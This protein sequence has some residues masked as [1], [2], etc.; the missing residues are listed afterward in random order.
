MPDMVG[1]VTFGSFDITVYAVWSTDY[2]N[3]GIPDVFQ[4]GFTLTYDANGGTGAPVDTHI[5]QY[6]ESIAVDDAAG[7]MMVAPSSNYVFMYWTDD[8]GV[9]PVYVLGDDRNSLPAEVHNITFSTSNVILYAVWGEDANGNGT[10]DILEDKYELEYNG[11]GGANVPPKS[12]G[13]LLNDTIVLDD[14][15]SMTN[16]SYVFVGWTLAEP[17]TYSSVYTVGEEG[18]LPAIVTDVT[19]TS[20]DIIVYA[21]W[22][23]DSNGNGIPDVYEDAYTVT[24]DTNGGTGSQTDANSYLMGSTATVLDQNDMANGTYA[25]IG[26]NTEA[27]GS[28]TS[29]AAGD[30]FTI[31]ADTVLFAQWEITQEILYTVTYDANGGTGGQTDANSPY[32][33]GSTVTVLDKND[34]ANGA[35]I[36]IGW[37]T[38]ADGSGTSYAVGGTFT[39][40]AD[41]VLYAQW[42]SSLTEDHIAYILG[43]PDG[44]VQPEGQITRA[45]VAMIFFRLLD[46]N[47]HPDKNDPVPNAFNDIKGDEWFAQ[48]V[49]YLA[50]INVLNG[51]EDGS[52]K[53]DDPIKRAEY[54]AVVAKFDSLT[55]GGTNAFIDV[56]DDHWALEVINSAYNKGWIVGYDDG[57]FRPDNCITR[58]EAVSLTNAVLNRAIDAATLQMIVNPYYD[59]T[60]LH[61][62][63]A[64]IIE[65]SIGHDYTRDTNGDEHWVAGSFSVGMVSMVSSEESG[66]E[67]EIQPD[68]ELEKPETEIVPEPETESENVPEMETEDRIVPGAEAE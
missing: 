48:A 21:V 52:F 6:G 24:Y 64:D 3:D 28:G 35:Y 43:Y 53:P 40:D 56:P 34:M 54:A 42:G 49:N 39:I 36:F 31:D 67:V 8:A 29:Y 10:A 66:E 58:A 20:R 19:F 55:Y 11:N 23:T 59:I 45:E 32:I 16:G 9:L 12:S 7:M 14:G 27:D 13:H 33:A 15:S 22:S 1:A 18:L 30:T 63:Y 50:S 51:Y 4:D 2:D 25:F 44:S 57:T 5:Y 68:T 46:E 26:W 38:E 37:N 60:T 47:T 17:N 41:T 61:W 62:A 65:A